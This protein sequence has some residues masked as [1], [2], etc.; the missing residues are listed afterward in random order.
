MNQM[1]NAIKTTQKKAIRQPH[2]LNI[3]HGT[4]TVGSD[5]M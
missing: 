5:A 3:I 2:T 4:E 1:I